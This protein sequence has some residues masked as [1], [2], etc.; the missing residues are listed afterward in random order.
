MGQNRKDYEMLVR[1]AEELE[2]AADKEHDKTKK[3]ELLDQAQELRVRA[4]NLP[5]DE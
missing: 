3:Q 1:A 2:E 5:D 4:D